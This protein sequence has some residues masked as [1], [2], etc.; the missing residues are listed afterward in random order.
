MH[1]V[2][3]SDKKTDFRFLVVD[4]NNATPE[5]YEAIKRCGY[6]LLTTDTHVSA[7]S[8]NRKGYWAFG[9]L[10]NVNELCNEAQSTEVKPSEVSLN[11]L[12]WEGNVRITHNGMGLIREAMSGALKYFKYYVV[13]TATIYFI[14]F[15]AQL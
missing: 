6:T 5:A 2:Y 1:L 15:L 3:L 11:M 4:S 10:A 7:T 12:R 8:K 13:A 9:E 14:A